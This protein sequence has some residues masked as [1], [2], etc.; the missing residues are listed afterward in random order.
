MTED[1]HAKST[2]CNLTG[3]DDDVAEAY[4]FFNRRTAEELLCILKASHLPHDEVRLCSKT[5][6]LISYCA[7]QFEFLA[8][9][10]NFV[11]MHVDTLI[12]LLS[13][14]QLTL[15]D[16]SVVHQIARWVRYDSHNRKCYIEKL[17]ALHPRD[18]AHPF[19][20]RAGIVANWDV[21]HHVYHH[22]HAHSRAH[23]PDSGHRHHH[24]HHHHHPHFHLPHALRFHRHHRNYD[25]S[26]AH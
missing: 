19:K 20:Y 9:E 7:A 12:S 26:Q 15:S 23:E 13:S 16:E 6:H 1:R 2:V 21:F 24:D 18:Q 4:T 11:H 25:Q 8:K 17:L 10:H 5:T 22:G 14:E 3:D